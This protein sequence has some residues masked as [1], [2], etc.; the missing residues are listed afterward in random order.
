M[1]YLLPDATC[2]SWQSPYTLR[3]PSAWASVGTF[4]VR[5]PFKNWGVFL[6][7]ETRAH[8]SPI[9]PL[10]HGIRCTEGATWDRNPVLVYRVSEC[11]VQRLSRDRSTRAI[12]KALTTFDQGSCAPALGQRTAF[13]WGCKSPIPAPFN[14]RTPGLARSALCYFGCILVSQPRGWFSVSQ[15]KAGVYGCKAMGRAAVRQ[16]RQ[17]FF[18]PPRSVSDQAALPFFVGQATTR[19]D[20]RRVQLELVTAKRLVSQQKAGVGHGQGRRVNSLLRS[21]TRRC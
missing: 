14:A 8:P 15:Q 17:L 7:D 6:K 1:C 18:D 5:E 11:G 19:W 21:A 3:L 16:A 4:S 2:R 12:H 20:Q 13:T 9:A 10:V